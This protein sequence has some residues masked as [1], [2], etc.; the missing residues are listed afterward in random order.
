VEAHDW[1]NFAWVAF[2]GAVA[3]LVRLERRFGKVMTRDEHERICMQRNDTLGEML[4]EIKAGLE[5]GSESRD[6]LLS[7]VTE[8]RVDIATLKERTARGEMER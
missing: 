7:Q 5:K 6:K 4:G 8:M 2:G 3:W 1:L